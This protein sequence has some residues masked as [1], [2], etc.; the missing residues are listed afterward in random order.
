MKKKTLILT[1][2]LCT[3]F[4]FSACSQDKKVDENLRGTI[5]TTSSEASEADSSA[6]D[7]SEADVATESSEDATES[8]DAIESTVEDSAETLDD[9]EASTEDAEA[10]TDDSEADALT[11]GH[12]DSNSYESTFLGIGCKFDSDWTFMTDEQIQENNKFAAELINNKTVSN[13]LEDGTV[14]TDMMVQ[15]VTTGSNVSV[16]IEKL[17]SLAKNVTEDQ[18][19]D[20]VSAQLVSTLEASG[21]SN[22][23]AEKITTTFLGSDHVALKITSTVSNTTVN[24]VQIPVKKGEYMACITASAF[25]DN[26]VDEM[27]DA[28]YS[29]D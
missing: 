6:E 8:T 10:V 1:L 9:A 11:L 16:A 12:S 23:N 5:S 20:A 22:V 27:V 28:F 13:A 4:S 7:S 24:Q 18:Y 15:N 3:V 29:L 26:T 21:F 2:A 17:Q 14:L 25:G 19:V